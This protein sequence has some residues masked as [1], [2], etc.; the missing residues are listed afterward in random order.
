MS[1]TAVGSRQRQAFKCLVQ[2]R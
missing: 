1:E 2:C